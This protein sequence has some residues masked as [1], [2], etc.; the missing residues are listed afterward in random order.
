M[1]GN[2]DIF[3]PLTNFTYLL[4]IFGA[5]VNALGY[6]DDVILVYANVKN[7]HFTY[8]HF[9]FASSIILIKL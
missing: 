4:V 3:F 6:G 7:F 2:D 9:T 1:V 8:A 5:R